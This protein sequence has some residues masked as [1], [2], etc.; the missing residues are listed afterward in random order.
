MSSYI[1]RNRVKDTKTDHSKNDFTYCICK[2]RCKLCKIHNTKKKS[3]RKL[4]TKKQ[5][6]KTAEDNCEIRIPSQP[7]LPDA[8]NISLLSSARSFLQSFLRLPPSC[9][10]CCCWLLQ[11]L[12]LLSRCWNLR[13]RRAHWSF[14]GTSRLALSAT[15]PLW[16]RESSSSEPS[17][18]YFLPGLI[19]GHLHA[20]SLART[21]SSWSPRLMRCSPCLYTEMMLMVNFH[22]SPALSPFSTCTWTARKR[23]T[24]TQRLVGWQSLFISIR[25]VFVIILP[26]MHNIFNTITLHIACEYKV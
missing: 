13:R 3:A 21:H 26:Y 11:H 4:K 17:N 2:I 8:S 10:D 18:R 12:P 14:Q 1:K 7:F 24:Q 9:A 25:V 15:T 20:T 16:P 22:H 5:T 23:N 19:L 6:K